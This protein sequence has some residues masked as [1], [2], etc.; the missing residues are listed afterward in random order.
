MRGLIVGL[1][2]AIGIVSCDECETDG[3]G[4]LST[5]CK[6]C[7]DSKPCGDSCIPRNQTCNVGPGCACSG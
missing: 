5:C 1:L 3:N 2:L 7:K 4:P 6:T